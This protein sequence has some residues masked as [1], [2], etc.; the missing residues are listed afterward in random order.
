MLYIHWQRMNI[1]SI[2]SLVCRLKR[3]RTGEG[4]NIILVVYEYE[5]GVASTG[6]KKFICSIRNSNNRS[7]VLLPTP[8]PRS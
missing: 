1:A 2:I 7:Q 3:I 8:R 5:V 6:H 4:L